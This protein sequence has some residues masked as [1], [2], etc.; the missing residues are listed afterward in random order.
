MYRVLQNSRTVLVSRVDRPLATATSG[1]KNVGVF[2]IFVCIMFTNTTRRDNLNKGHVLTQP[3][4]NSD[5]THMLRK[6]H[7]NVIDTWL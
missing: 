1:Q 6:K 3:P 4:H 2:L 7:T 5:K